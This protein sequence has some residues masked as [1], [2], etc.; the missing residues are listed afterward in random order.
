[1][2]IPPGSSSKPVGAHYFIQ[3]GGETPIRATIGPIAAEPLPSLPS[4]SLPRYVLGEMGKAD[5]LENV[6][7]PTIPHPINHPDP[8]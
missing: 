6:T 4:P 7:I 8:G 1:M 5:L 3:A 2:N